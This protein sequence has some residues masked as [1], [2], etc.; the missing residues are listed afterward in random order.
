[1]IKKTLMA[2]LMTASVLAGMAIAPHFASADHYY[3]RGRYQ[4]NGSD[5]AELRRDR[6]ELWR[7]QAELARDRED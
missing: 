1:M 5:W 4:N 3:G 7:D 6:Q 2:G